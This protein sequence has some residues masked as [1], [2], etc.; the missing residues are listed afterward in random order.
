M[1]SRALLE[2]T[3]D[4]AQ[5]VPEIAEIIGVALRAQTSPA[6]KLDVLHAL[7]D[8]ISRAIIDIEGAGA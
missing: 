1:K 2:C 6:A 3:F 7:S 8:E 4:L 5:P